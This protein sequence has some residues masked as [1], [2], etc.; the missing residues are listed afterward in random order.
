M[1]FAGLFGL[2]GPILRLFDFDGL[3]GLFGPIFGL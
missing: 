2:F 3:F 1:D